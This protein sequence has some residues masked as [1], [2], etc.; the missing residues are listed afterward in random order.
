MCLG[1]GT[2]KNVQGKYITIYSFTNYSNDLQLIVIVT[3]ISVVVFTNGL[4]I[5]TDVVYSYSCDLQFIVIVT[6][7]V[8]A[9]KNL[10]IVTNIVYS[11]SYELQF[12]VRV[13]NIVVATKIASL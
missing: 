9:T 4:V 8:V 13:T 6:N 7:I 2:G 11:Y 10:V 5:V 3:N 12:I 1:R